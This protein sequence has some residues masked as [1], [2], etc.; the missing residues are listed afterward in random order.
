VESSEWM[1]IKYYNGTNAGI[2]VI[3]KSL[4]EHE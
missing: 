1:G 4:A 3:A 2:A